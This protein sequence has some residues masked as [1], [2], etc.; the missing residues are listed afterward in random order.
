MLSETHKKEFIE[1]IDKWENIDL[2]KFPSSALNVKN[3]RKILNSTKYFNKKDYHNSELSSTQLAL[4]LLNDFVSSTMGWIHCNP[5]K[6]ETIA[7]SKETYVFP[8]EEDL[9]ACNTK[10]GMEHFFNYLVNKRHD[11]NF[12]VIKGNKGS[13]KT[14][15]QNYFLNTRTAD[16]FSEGITWFKVDLTKVLTY[17]KSY[18]RRLALLDYLYAQ[19]VYVYFRYGAENDEILKKINFEDVLKIAKVAYDKEYEDGMFS[20]ELIKVKEKCLDPY[21]NNNGL[22]KPFDFKIVA[23]LAQSIMSLVNKNKD[24]FLLFIDGLDNVDYI[25]DDNLNGWIN[26][27]YY[28]DIVKILSPSKLILN[29]R[30]ETHFYIEQILRKGKFTKWESASAQEFRIE[31]ISEQKIIA[32]FSQA[33][34]DKTLENYPQLQKQ[35]ERIEGLDK[36]LI[37]NIDR[38]I[39]KEFYEFG[40]QFSSFIVLAIQQRHNSLSIEITKDNV[41]EILYNG[42]LR[43]MLYDI[44][45]AYMYIDYLLWQKAKKERRKK[46]SVMSFLNVNSVKRSYLVIASLSRH[47]RIYYNNTNIFA[48]PFMLLH[49]FNLFNFINL[50][51]HLET[52][53]KDMFLPILILQYVKKKT[54]FLDEIIIHC[55]QH[56]FESE[57]IIKKIERKLLENGLLEIEVFGEENFDYTRL[58]RRITLRGEYALTSMEDMDILHSFSYEM[59]FPQPFIRSGIVKAHKND[60]SDYSSAQIS[61]VLS[62]LKLLQ[63]CQEKSNISALNHMEFFTEKIKNQLIGFATA[64]SDKEIENIMKVFRAFIDEYSTTYR[65]CNKTREALIDELASGQIS[66]DEFTRNMKECGYN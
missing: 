20:D 62:I 26:D 48:P 6:K 64:M 11:G 43:D 58:P 47:G 55:K 3:V 28:G 15:T 25:Y 18:S 10:I 1:F 51:E 17:Q 27:I 40:K 45:H 49:T 63:L 52:K 32:N 56:G 34:D 39:L 7:L 19:I 23:F 14:Y 42:S 30:P 37:E 22:N 46:E 31:K 60:L 9:N 65:V 50:R 35:L 54:C 44:K 29:C 57:D 5:S 8:I 12:V 24:R 36:N 2:D 4:S 38:G 41:L 59:Y 53:Y 21:F 13:G 66:L 16:L 61:N 33:I